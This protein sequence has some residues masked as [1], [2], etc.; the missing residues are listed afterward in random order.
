[1]NEYSPDYWQIIKVTP[2]EGEV[3]YKLFATW[4][5]GYTQGDSWRI[6]SGIVEVKEVDN[7]LIFKGHSG[8]VYYV[9][10]DEYNYRTSMYSQSILESLKKRGDL[11]GVGVEI[12]PFSTN[13]KELFWSSL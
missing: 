7:L 6:N 13:F 4:V 9:R 5:G 10:N 11:I 3:S 2:P 12:L 1:M 8:S